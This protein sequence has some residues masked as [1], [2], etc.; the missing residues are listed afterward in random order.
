MV[1]KYCMGTVIDQSLPSVL[2]DMKTDEVDAGDNAELKR[3]P[4]ITVR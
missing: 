3:C 1:T 4:T 2:G